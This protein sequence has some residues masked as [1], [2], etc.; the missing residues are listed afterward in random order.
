MEIS[1]E[2]GPKDVTHAAKA[3]ITLT[4]IDYSNLFQ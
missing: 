2:Q 4:T 1:L 3:F